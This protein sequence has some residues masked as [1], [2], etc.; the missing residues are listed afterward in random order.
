M[1]VVDAVCF[2]VRIFLVAECV[3]IRPCSEKG[4]DGIECVQ[5]S[6]ASQKSF[7]LLNQT[8]FVEAL[9]LVSGHCCLERQEQGQDFR[10]PPVDGGRRVE[11]RH[12]KIG[13]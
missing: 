9:E 13:I 10:T 2:A 11:R 8:V 3:G 5:T 4:F 1:V 7:F 6:R 12:V